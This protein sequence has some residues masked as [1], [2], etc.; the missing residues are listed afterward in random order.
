[1]YVQSYLTPVL[2]GYQKFSF[3]VSPLHQRIVRYGFNNAYY[4]MR[5]PQFLWEFPLYKL[6]REDDPY[7]WIYR[8]I[9]ES[10][11]DTFYNARW[12]NQKPY[13]SVN[14][15][16]RFNGRIFL[17]TS[18][19]TFSAGAYFAGIFK[20]NNLGTIVGRE[21]GGRAYM[22]SD[23][24]PI[25][26]PHSNLMYLIPV[27]KFIVADDD[28]DRGIIPDTLVDLTPE[29]YSKYNDQDIEK[30]IGLIKEEEAKK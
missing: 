16:N 14:I 3:K 9:F 17:L 19:E 12:E 7:Y 26:L 4:D 18:H 10:K 6:I 27:A 30:V 15:N 28:P 25:F 2:R 23:P 8:G 11:P 29:N 13:L 21:T 1:M 24:R 22:L 20:T 5:L